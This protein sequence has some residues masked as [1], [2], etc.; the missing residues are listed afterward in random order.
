MNY[1]DFDLNIQVEI[2][3]ITQYADKRFPKRR[4]FIEVVFWDDGDYQISC[5]S[6]WG[7][8]KDII[9][10]KKSVGEYQYWKELLS[11]S[12]TKVVKIKELK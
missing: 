3:K 4:W 8:Y 7:K 11:F 2:K 1:K 12:K 10:F 9:Y 5:H 6:S